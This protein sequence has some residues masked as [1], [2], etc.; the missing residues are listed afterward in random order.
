MASS[1]NS[2]SG[3][4]FARAFGDRLRNYLVEKGMTQV[5]AARAMGLKDRKSGKPSK[6]RL[7]KYLNDSP[8]MPEAHLLYL[9]C[10]KLEG[11][12][13]EHQGQR[14][15]AETVRRKKG[16]PPAEQ[17]TFRFNRQFNLTDK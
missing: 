13:F 12:N 8:S 11:F 9:A 2:D 1:G 5:D 16:A 14:L 3:G 4:D 6:S 15:N 17:M 7:N 10:T